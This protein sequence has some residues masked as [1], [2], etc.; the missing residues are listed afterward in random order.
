MAAALLSLI[1]V[2][3]RS[4]F[5]AQRPVAQSFDDFFVVKQDFIF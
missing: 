2:Y 3:H 4:L 5:A 1:P